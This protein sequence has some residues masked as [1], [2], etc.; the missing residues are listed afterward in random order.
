MCPPDAKTQT[1]RCLLTAQRKHGAARIGVY[2]SPPWRRARP[3]DH[4]QRC[5]TRICKIFDAHHIYQSDISFQRPQRGVWKHESTPVTFRPDRTLP[6][7]CGWCRGQ[8]RS[9]PHACDLRIG[10]T[11]II[12]PRACWHVLGL[13]ACP[14]VSDRQATEPVFA[15]RTVRC[16]HRTDLTAGVS[17]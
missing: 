5:R 8:Y 17:T 10:T 16:T 2:A 9:L 12:A 1:I 14:R 4:R 11:F 15:A 3:T 7:A 6:S 13:T